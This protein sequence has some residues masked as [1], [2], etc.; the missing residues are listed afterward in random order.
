MRKPRT[1]K[2]YGPKALL[3]EWEQLIS[4]AINQGVHAYGAAISDW[5]EVVEC[6]PAYASLLVKLHHPMDTDRIRERIYSGV[7]IKETADD[8]RRIVLPV[9]Y[10]GEFGV[11]LTAVAAATNLS[12]QDVIELH[13]GRTYQVY[14]LGFQP[15]FA[16][17]GDLDDRLTLPRRA[18]PRSS[19]PAGSVAIAE[20]QTAVY[21]SPS[22]GGWQLIGRCP[23][24]VVN[25][26]A[27]QPEALA[28]LQPG[29]E[30]RFT[31]ID[32][33]KFSQLQQQPNVWWE[34]FK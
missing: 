29:D 13:S 32:E 21:P 34:Q 30:V 9:C 2:S 18:A 31:P 10:G 24:P 19:V 16:F 11:D 4:P 5:P 28:L 6:I 17:L 25:F 12:E 27:E 1:I 23:V 7:V 8:R 3:L 26:N 20:R 15:G 14:Q 22:P 33:S